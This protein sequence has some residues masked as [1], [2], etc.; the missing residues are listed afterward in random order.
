MFRLKRN[1]DRAACNFADGFERFARIDSAQ[2][3]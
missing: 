1:L 2:P 3:V